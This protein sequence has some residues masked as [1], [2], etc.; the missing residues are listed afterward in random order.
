M[1]PNI[2]LA[3]SSKYRKMLMKRLGLSFV[4]VPPNISEI[5]K[6]RESA[7]SLVRRLSEEKA[8]ALSKT[9]TENLIIGSDQVA[10]LN[11]APLN[12]KKLS[13]PYASDPCFKRDVEFLCKPGTQEKATSQLKAQSG[14]RVTFLTGISVLNTTKNLIETDVI[15]TDVIFRRL[16]ETEITTYLQKELPYDCAGSFKAEGLGISLLDAVYSCD[17]T[18]LIGLPLIRLSKMLRKNQLN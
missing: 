4:C 18:A 12:T 10:V 14:K 8:R 6:D 15:I 17:P 16:L 11:P 3:S 1:L 5:R 9:Y 13:F 2:V 7:D